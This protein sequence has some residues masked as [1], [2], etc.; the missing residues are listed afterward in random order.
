MV[1]T[2]IALDLHDEM[3]NDTMS[4]RL[5]TAFVASLL[6]LGRHNRSVV[7]HKRCSSCVAILVRKAGALLDTQG[8]GSR[9]CRVSRCVPSRAERECWH[10][11]L[12]LGMFECDWHGRRGCERSFGSGVE[13][14][15]GLRQEWGKDTIIKTE[16]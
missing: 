4:V 9:I 13:H 15:A 10:S 7:E 3:A 2:C 16:R 6:R 11:G 12:E 8:L 14:Q 5:I 1:R